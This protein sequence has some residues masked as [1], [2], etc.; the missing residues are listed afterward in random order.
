MV[1]VLLGLGDQGKTHHAVEFS[2][3]VQAS[4][5]TS[6]TVWPDTWSEQTSRLGF[7]QLAGKIA[8]GRAF[9][10]T[11][12]FVLDRLARQP[13]LRL[14][15]FDSYVQPG[16]VPAVVSH[17]TSAAT[18]AGPNIVPSLH[19]GTERL[20]RVVHVAGIASG[21][22]LDWLSDKGDYHEHF[23]NSIFIFL[24]FFQL[25]LFSL[26]YL[27]QG[28]TLLVF[29]DRLVKIDV[30]FNYAYLTLIELVHSVLDEGCTR[31]GQGS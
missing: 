14:L 3:T 2:R 9:E 28:N 5:R 15:V 8:P 10:V 21:D 23:R 27:N 25:F 31:Y 4:E 24:L 7:R 22:A 1:V 11:V 13:Q 26:N 16:D 20:R 30:I 6:V 17:F 29:I 18:A 19:S 12:A